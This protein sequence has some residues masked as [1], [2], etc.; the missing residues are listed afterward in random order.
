MR[1]RDDSDEGEGE[2]EAVEG[3][4]LLARIP[5]A[6]QVLTTA[7]LAGRVQ[8][9]QRLEEA[10][11]ALEVNQAQG[12]VDKLAELTKAFATDLEQ[13]SA[14]WVKAL[15]VL[16]GT[17]EDDGA[18]MNLIMLAGMGALGV[19]YHL[20]QRILRKTVPKQKLVFMDKNCQR[21][22]Q[23]FLQRPA[24]GQPGIRRVK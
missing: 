23:A 18:K 24:D 10:P 17:G 2:G 7:A 6:A 4:G 22:A 21:Q 1:D 14:K 3:P 12:T 16:D 5:L 9:I 20:V 15:G 19:R 8:D 13:L 11:A